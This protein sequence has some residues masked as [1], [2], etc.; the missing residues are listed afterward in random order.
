MDKSFYVYAYLREDGTPYYIGKGKGSRIT[1]KHNVSVPKDAN[2]RSILKENI[3]EDDAFALEIQLIASYSRKDLGTGILRNMTDGGEGASGAKRTPEQIARN[4][5]K[6]PDVK[7]KHKDRMND[8]EVIAKTISGGKSQKGK[9]YPNKSK[10]LKGIPKPYNVGD[11]NPAKRPEV[12]EAISSALIGRENTWMIGDKNHMRS[13]HHRDRMANNN[14]MRNP[15]A[16]KKLK[17][18]KTG[19][20]HKQVTCPHCGK[21]GGHA[22]M[23]RYHF[24]NCKHKTS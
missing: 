13:E 11:N 21:S 6:R 9:K 19:V 22:N 4:G 12:R 23:T 3:S 5:M 16:V 17:A 15:D 8:P 10:A 1:A 2:R 7:K 24:D 14:P 20:K 18:A